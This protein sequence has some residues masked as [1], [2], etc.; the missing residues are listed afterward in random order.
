MKACPYC[1]E[2][3]NEAAVVCPHCRRSQP[4]RYK[5]LKW[6][7]LW[8]TMA[9]IAVF[10]GLVW[11]GSSVNSHGTNSVLYDAMA[12]YQPG[13]THDQADEYVDQIASAVNVSHAEA[14]RIAVTC[15]QT[16]I[17]PRLWVKV[18]QT[19]AV[20]ARLKAEGAVPA[21]AP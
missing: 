4:G 15:V 2:Q 18:A 21:S 6:G 17:N 11:I 3:I 20:L 10:V 7:M 14:Q 12:I 16:N 1:A 8:V 13:L 5:A 9:L 19:S